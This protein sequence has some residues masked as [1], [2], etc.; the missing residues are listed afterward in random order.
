MAFAQ[1]RE[2]TQEVSDEAQACPH[3]GAPFPSN[4]SFHG[5]GYEYKSATTI[6]G[7]PFVH[8]AI[9]RDARGRLRVAKGFIAVGQFAVGAITI[10]QFGIGFLFGLGQFVLGLA[11][12]AQFAGALAFGLGQ[13][14]A[15]YVAIGQ[16]AVGEY[17][18]AS[19]GWGRYLWSP[20]IKDPHAVD[21]FRTLAMKLGLWPR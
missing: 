15:G 9:G 10:A 8:V 13:F 16:F 14:A 5:W 7:Y 2:C 21:L 20:Q 1:C 11:V 12:V 19:A 6:L 17:V 3:C 18:M 4:R